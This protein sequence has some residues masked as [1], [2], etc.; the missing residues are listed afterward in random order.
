MFA[1]LRTLLIV[2]AF[3]ALGTAA[4]AQEANKDPYPSRPV[5]IFVPYPPGGAVDIVARTLDDELSKRWGQTVVIENRPGAG[6]VIA[7]QALVQSP[8]DG[9]T[10]DRRCFRA[11]SPRPFLRQAAL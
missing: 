8:P 7:E 11:R 9:Y 10:L 2:I 6:G 4:Q 1:R 3:A 5:H